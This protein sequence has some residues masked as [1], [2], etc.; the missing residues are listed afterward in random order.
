M[1]IIISFIRF[2]SEKVPPFNKT[3]CILV[4]K[5][6]SQYQERNCF[7]NIDIIMENSKFKSIKF[8][9][10]II[11]ENTLKITPIKTRPNFKRVRFVLKVPFEIYTMDGKIIAGY[12]PNIQKDIVMFIPEARDQTTFK[13]EVETSSK[14]L[15][16]P[17]N[18]QNKLI[19]SAGVFILIRAVC[20]VPLL[21]P[22]LESYHR[23]GSINVENHLYHT[24]SNGVKNN[25][26]MMIS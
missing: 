16:E 14:L 15:T 4:D 26:L 18:F 8:K 3:A 22:T 1:P 7:E 6:F 12:L 20:K 5:V 10:G 21:I 13:I 2:Y 23:H 9:P 25:L 24:F 19:F 17:D 11:I